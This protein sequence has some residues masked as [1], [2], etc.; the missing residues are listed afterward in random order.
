MITVKLNQEEYE[1]ILHMLEMEYEE[2]KQLIYNLKDN[3]LPLG[4]VQRETAELRLKEIKSTIDK[5][6]NSFVLSLF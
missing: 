2:I 5:M 4:K 1:T 3:E 6:N